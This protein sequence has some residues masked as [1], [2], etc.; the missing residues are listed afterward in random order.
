[1]DIQLPDGLTSTRLIAAVHLHLAQYPM[2]TSETLSKLGDGLRR[3]HENKSIFVD[4]SVRANLNLPKL[5]NCEH[6]PMYITLF[7]TTDNCNTEYTERLHIDLTKDAYRA[8]NFKD[9]FPQM[10]LWLD[11]KEK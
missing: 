4:L 11:R 1:L 3:F 6:Y 2:H 8:T 10:T 9:K 7:G 5:H